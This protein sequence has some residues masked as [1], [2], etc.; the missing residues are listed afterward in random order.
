M[1]KSNISNKS[2]NESPRQSRKSDILCPYLL[3]RGWCKKSNRCDYS[4]QRLGRQTRV[5]PKSEV[6]CPFLKNRG[7]CLKETR[8]DF[9]HPIRHQPSTQPNI[10]PPHIPT[11][12]HGPF[13]EPHMRRDTRSPFLF[14]SPWPV[15]PP[16]PPP[17]MNVPTWPPPTY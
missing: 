5:T 17:L 16:F 4:H 3:R 10:M 9:L 13:F 1:L 11:Y 7:Y 2:L 6:P 8:C 15:A 14:R 12:H